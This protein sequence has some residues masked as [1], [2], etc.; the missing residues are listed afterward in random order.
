MNRYFKVLLI[1][2][3]IS[4]AG[5][6]AEAANKVN[7][8]LGTSRGIYNAVK[9]PGNTYNYVQNGGDKNTINSFFGHRAVP[10]VNSSG[11]LVGAYYEKTNSTGNSLNIQQTGN[12]NN[13]ALLGY[14]NNNTVQLQQIGDRNYSGVSLIGNNNIVKSSI[15]GTGSF[16]ASGVNGS[17]NKLTA[18]VKGDGNRTGLYTQYSPGGGTLG[19]GNTLDIS[20]EGKGNHTVLNVLGSNATA[21]TTVVGDSNYS[22]VALTA[23]AHF[24]STQTGNRNT[25]SYLGGANETATVSQNGDDNFIKFGYGDAR[26]NPYQ[27]LLGS[28]G[29]NSIDI[30]QSGNANRAT[31]AN[32]AANHDLNIAQFNGDNTMTV[33]F[34][35]TAGG[36]SG[37][38]TTSTITQSGGKS[39]SLVTNQAVTISQ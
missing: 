32:Y 24:E 20:V 13:A 7:T 26:V 29:N 9:L 28:G 34:L 25:L 36:T 3:V 6:A 12:Y 38:H 18:K 19:S 2:T 17:N 8:L 14:G 37:A 23:N 5:A 27:S 35:A 30:S 11:K 16:F 21:K 10:I 1:G 22:E 4:G 15:E 31:L 33:A 39:L